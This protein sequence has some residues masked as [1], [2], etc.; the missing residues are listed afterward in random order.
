MSTLLRDPLFLMIAAVVI[1]LILAAGVLILP[2]RGHRTRP[3]EHRTQNYS[4]RDLRPF[5]GA[6]M[7]EPLFFDLR[8]EVKA[9]Q[10]RI[11]ELEA[12]ISDLKK[13]QPSHVQRDLLPRHD[14]GHSED[15]HF[16][17]RDALFVPLADP[18]TGP[19]ASQGKSVELLAGVVVPS[20]SLISVGSLVAGEGLGPAKLYINREAEIDHIALEQWSSYF[21][22]RGGEAYQHYKTVEPSLVE[23]D[24]T[25]GRG[26]L[27]KRGV[28]EAV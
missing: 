20:R 14:G 28:V 10:Q 18:R 9:M 23:W 13:T 5:S 12:A 17:D 19:W 7:S 22:F 6:D 15:S 4:V 3:H 26:H 11:T 21:D 16:I 2:R 24:D 27:I 25:S 8:R 1:I